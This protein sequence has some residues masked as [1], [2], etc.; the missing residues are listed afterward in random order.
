M[1]EIAVG[2]IN[3]NTR[4][5]LEACLASVQQEAPSKIVVVDNASSDSSV[6]LVKVE[7][8]GVVLLENQSNVGYGAAANQAIAACEEEY[9]L[10]LN[11]DTL[12]N[13]GA[14]HALSEYLVL[15]PRVGVAGPRLINPDGTFQQSCYP[16]PTP[17]DIFLD[18]GNLSRVIRWVPCLRDHYIRTWSHDRARA[19]PYTLGAALAIRRI[20]IESVN[21]F[22]ESYFIYYEEVDLCYRLAKAGWQTH[23]AP[24]TEVI[25]IGGASTRQMRSDMAVQFYTS[26]AQFYR[27]HYSKLRM[28]ELILI[29]QSVAFTRLLRDAI[30][31]HLAREPQRR[32]RLAM[33]INAWQRLL[34][35]QWRSGVV[36]P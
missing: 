31:L 10:L 17:L 8:P 34:M 26:L 2:I 13:P 5:L 19:V 6:D 18:V 22:D 30:R 25:H 23:Y 32:A 15:N 28:A 29:I 11:S 21:G 4:E 14:L 20:A 24:V 9:I 1:T 16:L 35:G 3:F 12:L 7:F 33:D 27:Q 36:Y